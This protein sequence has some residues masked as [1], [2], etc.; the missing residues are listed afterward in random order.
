MR[1]EQRRQI[2]HQLV[3]GQARPGEHQ[4]PTDRTGRERAE[5]LDDGQVRVAGREGPFGRRAV[6]V[7]GG[8]P[9]REQRSRLATLP[10]LRPHP[11]DQQGHDDHEH[12]DD[13][14]HRGRREGRGAQCAD[15]QPVP[16]VGEPG[17][18]PLTE[19]LLVLRPA[20]LTLQPGA[21]PLG[22][23]AQHGR[24][25]GNGGHRGEEH[26]EHRCGQASPGA[27]RC[28]AAISSTSSASLRIRWSTYCSAVTAEVNGVVRAATRIWVR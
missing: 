20:E 11:G 17:Q 22:V 7:R 9:V 1:R 19:A 26:R 14:D 13:H 3:G 16:E 21:G 8:L 15:P 18:E 28:E 5:G 27:L 12:H 4:P 2:H 6:L 24:H 25:A 10:G 23:R